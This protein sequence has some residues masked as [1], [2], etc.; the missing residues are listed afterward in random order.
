MTGSEVELTD[1]AR[2]KTAADAY[3]HIVAF[4]RTDRRVVGL[5]LGGGRG[6]GVVRPWSDY[7]VYLVVTPDTSIEEIYATLNDGAGIELS[8]RAGQT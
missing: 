8:G 4:A 2:Q 1:P 5:V 6:K 7:D 3:E